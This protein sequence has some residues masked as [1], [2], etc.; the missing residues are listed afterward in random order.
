MK[1]LKSS[2]LPM[3]LCALIAVLLLKLALIT[4]GVFADRRAVSQTPAETVQQKPEPGQ[5]PEKT[6]VSGVSMVAESYAAQ[7][8]GEQR[9]KAVRG[10]VNSASGMVSFIQQRENEL[11]K[12]EEQLN[13][14]EARL[15]KLEQEIEKK[16]KDLL[17]IQKEIQAHRD[18]KQEVQAGKVKS[19]ARIYGTMKPKEAA[20]LLENLDDKLVQDIIA[21]MTPDEAASILSLMDIKKAAKISEALSGR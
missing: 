9:P 3:A 20:K 10:D 11:R 1:R 8:E 17:V 12:K 4:G 18:E 13:E 19:L 7:S 21:T 6:M 14:K 15:A 2:L 5:G 16:T